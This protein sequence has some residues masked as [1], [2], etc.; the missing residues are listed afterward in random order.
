M[1]PL[2]IIRENKYNYRGLL[3]SIKA[4]E[5]PYYTESNN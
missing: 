1:N 5:K 2:H 3:Y 4:T